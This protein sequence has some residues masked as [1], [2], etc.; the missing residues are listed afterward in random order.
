MLGKFSFWAEGHL[1]IS[2][3]TVAARFNTKE[4]YH[5]MANPTYELLMLKHIYIYIYAPTG[6]G[7]IMIVIMI[8]FTFALLTNLP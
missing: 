8:I 3:K 6:G 5:A 7:L 2:T 4:T 1:I